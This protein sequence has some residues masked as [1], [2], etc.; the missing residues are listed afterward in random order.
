MHHD[1][2][3]LMR[4]GLVHRLLHASGTLHRTRH[5][6][7]WL[8]ALLVGLALGPLL[9]LCARAGTL[10]PGSG[11]SG[12][13]I[14]LLA[15]YD[16]LARLLL[17]LPL[18]VLAA[19]RSD[20]LLRGA[21]RQLTHGSVVHPTRRPRLASLLDHVRDQRDSWLPEAVCLVLAFAPAWAGAPVAGV[22]PDGH[23]SAAGVWYT[24]VSVPVLRLLL[25]LW[26]WR[27]LLWSLLLW[28]L[29][30]VGLDLHPQHPD[31]AG[32]LGFLGRAQMRFA[33]V[34]AAG[35]IM[36]T[37]AFLNQML[38]QDQ[39]LFA[40]RHLI[41]GYVIG[42]T[43][44]LTAPLL[45]LMPT[46]VRAKRHALARFDAL[47]NRAAALFDHRWQ[48]ASDATAGGES[49][50]DHNDASAYADF[51]GV[52]QSLAAMRAVPLSRWNLLGLALPATAPMLPLLLV[53]MSIDE[54]AAKLLGLLA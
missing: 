23:P 14:A 3:S 8:A 34:A 40:L 39:S 42:A 11:V 41:A 29:P 32:G 28:R 1:H 48:A 52:Y 19:P 5:L 25:L 2:Y 12:V 45:L 18:L 21:L 24:A 4:G 7:V 6:S 53:A 16:T 30:Q 20:A 38:H 49:L 17:A 13:S 50:L 9:P 26:F 33:P 47:G 31:R 37:G 44:V 15:D 27:F 35:A 10:W 51:S 43:F 36:L 22:L 46:L 54:L